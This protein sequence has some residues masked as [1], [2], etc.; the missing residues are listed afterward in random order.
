MPGWFWAM[1][2]FVAG[3][4]VFGLGRWR[5]SVA[6]PAEGT[7]SSGALETRIHALGQ[8]QRAVLE[9]LLRH[10]KALRDPNEVF[11]EKRTFGQ[12]FAD[13]IAAWG[14]SWTFIGLFVALLLVWIYF[15]ATS[16]ARFDPF[17]FILLNLIL[18]CVAAL[19]APVIMMSQNRQAAKDRHDARLDYETNVHAELEIQSLQAKMDRL[20]DRQWSDLVG[21]QERQIEL[22][23]LIVKSKS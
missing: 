3:A 21:M 14:G 18:S 15:N 5:R 1:G 7:A 4:M 9:R 22:L 11:D 20:N 2:G 6:D 8:R 17:P 10:D 23:E 13:Q 16:A 12:R 19:Q